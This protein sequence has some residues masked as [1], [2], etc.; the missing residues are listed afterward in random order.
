MSPPQT[1]IARNSP[2]LALKEGEPIPE[3]YAYVVK[4]RPNG[5][6][7]GRDVGYA[8][9]VDLSTPPKDAMPIAADIAANAKNTSAAK[10][11]LT[12]NLNR[13]AN[14]A[15]AKEMKD[16]LASGRTPVIKLSEDSSD[17]KARWHAAAKEVAYRI[18]D[19]TKESWKEY[20]HFEKETLHRE[21][22]RQYPFDPP[23]DPKKVDKYLSGHLRTSRAVWKAH[24]LKYGDASRHHNCPAVAWEK[25]IKWWCTDACQQESAEMALRRSR[26]Q[27]NSRTGRKSLLETMDAEVSDISFYVLH[28]MP[29][30]CC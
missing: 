8:D 9:T 6:P 11:N 30:L 7:P 1:R 29:N 23:L 16:A 13:R 2:L 25:L 22:N 18:L 19:L 17:L 28:L 3:G 5:G 26:V 24:W 15:L 12:R 14:S 10:R 21:L 20:T 4:E 27:T